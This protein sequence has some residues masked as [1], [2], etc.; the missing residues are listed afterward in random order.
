MGTAWRRAKRALAANLCV[1]IPGNLDD[2]GG[3][4]SGGHDAGRS[5]DA[6]AA[7]SPTT[8]GGASD[9]QAL[10]PTTPTPTSSGLRLTRSGSRSSKVRLFCYLF[11]TL[12]ELRCLFLC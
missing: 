8:S 2:D 3:S 6:A 10:M 12:L 1:Y 5:S 4:P 9:Y 7:S 11:T